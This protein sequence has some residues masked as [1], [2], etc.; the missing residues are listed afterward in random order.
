LAFLTEDDLKECFRILLHYY[1]KLYS[2]ALQNRPE[3]TPVVTIGA[4]DPGEETTAKL[5][6]N[7]KQTENV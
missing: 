1:D 6:M 4:T 2:K 5:I 3:T 7:S